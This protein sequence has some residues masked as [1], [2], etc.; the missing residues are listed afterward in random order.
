MLAPPMLGLY[1]VDRDTANSLLEAWGH[2][3]GPMRRPSYAIEAHHALLHDGEPVALAMSGEPVR[4]TVGQ[5]GIARSVCVELTRLCAARPHLCRPMLRLWREFVF[6]AVA[7]RHGRRLAVS[8]QD[9]AL[10]RGDVYR[11]DGW[12]DI[13]RAGGGGGNSRTGRPSRKM[14]VWAWPPEVAAELCQEDMP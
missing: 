1:P 6:P 12:L 10:H 8:Y 11:F 2:R 5:S 4:E 7:A 14:R 13:C 9:E 3:M